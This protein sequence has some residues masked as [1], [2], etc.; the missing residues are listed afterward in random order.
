[1]IFSNYW[2][3]N[4]QFTNIN[5]TNDAF[6][7]FSSIIWQCSKIKINIKK[8][9]YKHYKYIQEKILVNKYIIIIVNY[10]YIS[11]INVKKKCFEKS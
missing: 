9:F 7:D 3:L 5:D 6:K 11:L 1:M 4:Q 8:R 10:Y 2:Y